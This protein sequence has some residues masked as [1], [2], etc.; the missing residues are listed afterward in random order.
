MP[1]EPK[2]AAENPTDTLLSLE[3][4]SLKQ[5]QEEAV[6]LGAKDV[7]DFTTKKQM[8]NV[9]H[10]LQAKPP[11][12]PAFQTTTPGLDNPSADNRMWMD[13]R[14]RMMAILWEQMA[15]GE[16]TRVL[17]PLE[18]KEKPGKVSVVVKGNRKEFIPLG[19][20][21]DTVCLNGYVWMIPKGVYSEVPNRVADELGTA[22]QETANAG[23]AFDINRIDPNTGRPVSD[24]L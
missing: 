23:A 9:I 8:L 18:G 14:S 17:I 11:A 20:A 21:I 15:R 2:A 5:L 12:A 24:Q 6:K 22:Q 1:D 16:K 4:M 13:K 19:G 7:E 3:E 10:T